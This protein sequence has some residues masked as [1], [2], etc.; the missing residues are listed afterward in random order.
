MDPKPR[1]NLS[2]LSQSQSKLGPNFSKK[3][4]WIFLDSLV[5]NEVFQ[6]VFLTPRTKKALPGVGFGPTQQAKAGD[7]SETDHNR[8]DH[9]TYSV[10]QKEKSDVR[11][12]RMRIALFLQYDSRLKPFD[13]LLSFRSSRRKTRR[14]NGDSRPSS[15]TEAARLVAA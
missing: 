4:A 13:R 9:S 10:I 3:N 1:Q 12:K 8:N 14:S 5:Q 15:G 11:S 2:K 6:W 7:S